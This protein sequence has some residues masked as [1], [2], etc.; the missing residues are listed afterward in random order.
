MV[1]WLLTE[2]FADRSNN[3][4][5]VSLTRE[6]EP[7]GSLFETTNYRFDFSSVEKPYESYSGINVRLRYF[8]RATV[9]KSYGSS[10]MQIESEFLVFNV[11]SGDEEALNTLK[12]EVG[13]SIIFENVT[14]SR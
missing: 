3:F 11:S 9:S 4:D 13:M 7:E 1:Y 10:N 8:V 14:A 12:M 6:L 2:Q 5:F